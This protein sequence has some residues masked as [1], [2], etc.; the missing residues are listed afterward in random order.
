MVKKEAMPTW[1]VVV[2][3]IHRKF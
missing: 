1:I 2:V 3:G